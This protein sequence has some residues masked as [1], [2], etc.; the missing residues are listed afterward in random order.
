MN[1]LEIINVYRQADFDAVVEALRAAGYAIVV[2]PE[3]CIETDAP[4]AVVKKIVELHGGT[5]WIESTVG[6]G[7]TFFFTLPK[8][9]VASAQSTRSM[10]VQN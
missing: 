1:R 9:N 5:V 3:Y 6:E 4:L 8:L 7:S 10:N 2:R